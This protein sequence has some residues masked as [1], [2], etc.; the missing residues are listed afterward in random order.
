MDH[1]LLIEDEDDVAKVIAGR[2][3]SPG[4]TG[5]SFHVER[6]DCLQNGLEQLT[7]RAAN[8]V[9]LDLNLPDSQ[10]FDTFLKVRAH[11]PEMPIVVLTAL[12]DEGIGLNAV[13]QGAQDYLVKGGFEGHLL[14]RVAKY[15][16][17]RHRLQ[18]EIRELALTDE[19][20]GLY[21]RRGFLML[22]EQQLKLAQRTKRESLLV[23]IDVDGLKAINDTLG[24][25]EGD[26]AIKQTAVV[27]KRTFRGSDI[28][29]RIG[30]D[31]FAA[32]AVEAREG[33]VPILLARL[34][35]NIQELNAQPSHRHLLSLSVGMARSDSE[36]ASSVEALLVEADKE[37]YDRRRAKRTL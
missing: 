13:S 28:L 27:L 18:K 7:K 23:Y 15:A 8:V 22:A 12:D 4:L 35:K 1:V 10:G 2:L 36:G 16:I 26:L 24:H 5:S 6:A 25:T 32:F 3:T 19:L 31:E 33:T 37:L 11:S 9:L 14:R 17:E 20:T 29:A 21:N 34:Q 30:G